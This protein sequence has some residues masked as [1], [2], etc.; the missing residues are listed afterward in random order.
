[1]QLETGEKG[2]LMKNKAVHESNVLEEAYYKLQPSEQRLILFLASVI[3]S[4]KEEDFKG[5]M[6]STT[7][8]ARI[9]QLK[10]KEEYSEVKKT[11]RSLISKNFEIQTQAGFLRT[12]WLSSAEYVEDSAKVIVE[13]DSK[14]KPYLLQLKDKHTKYGLAQ[15][16]RLK[17][18]YSIRVYELLKQYEKN[19]EKYF[20]VA[21]L[22]QKLGIEP[23]K[24]INYNSLKVYVLTAA[25]VE[26]KAKTDISFE[27]EEIKI[28][29]KVGKIRFLIKSTSV[30]GPK[31]IT[32]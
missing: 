22:R 24:Y 19:G 31:F 17:S 2:Y 13:F 28:G 21:D 29:R 3:R 16:D 32:D 20:L 6:F 15:V 4:D 9:A 25:Q 10:H 27:F 5:Y 11:T 7:E 14:L 18:M 23:G 26:L 8:C 12:S 1:M 30:V